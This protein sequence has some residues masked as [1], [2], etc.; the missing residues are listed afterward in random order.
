MPAARISVT[1]PGSGDAVSLPRTSNAPVDT[2]ASYG[3]QPVPHQMPLGDG[4]AKH[5]VP[6]SSNNVPVAPVELENHAAPELLS[7]GRTATQ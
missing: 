6:K 5:P 1:V 3:N 7:S 4:T 2:P